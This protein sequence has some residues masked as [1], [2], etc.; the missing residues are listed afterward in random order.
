MAWLERTLYRLLLSVM[1]LGVGASLHA[2]L[3]GRGLAP[4]LSLRIL[5]TAP[6]PRL[7]RS[8]RGSLG[9]L[10]GGRPLLLLPRL[11]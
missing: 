8:R 2:R 3:L 1:P 11:K 6:L 7:R 4:G 10:I 5:P 9:W